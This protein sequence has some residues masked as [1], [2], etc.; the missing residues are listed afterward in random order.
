MLGQDNLVAALY[1]ELTYDDTKRGKTV[2]IKPEHDRRVESRARPAYLASA[3]AGEV[4]R[5]R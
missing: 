4:H 5:R 3:S 2:G 1:G